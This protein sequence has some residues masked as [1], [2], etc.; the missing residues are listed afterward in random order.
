M[1]IGVLKALFA[2]KLSPD[3]A[4]PG[5]EASTMRRALII[6]VVVAVAALG[7]VWAASV[8]APCA[9]PPALMAKIAPAK[10]GVLPGAVAAAD[11]PRAVEPPAV[12]VVPAVRREFVDRLF[13]SGTLVA[14]EEAQVVARIDGLTIVE[15]DAEDGDQRQAGTGARPPRSHPARRAS[16]RERRGDQAGRRGDRPGAEHDRAV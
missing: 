3:P 5:E 12:T 14:R 2:G 11:Q 1:A 9:L 7:G 8:V 6:V 16:G 10:I 15:V 4:T 13:V